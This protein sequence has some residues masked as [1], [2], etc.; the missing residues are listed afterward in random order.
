MAVKW[1]RDRTIR[2]YSARLQ[3]AFLLVASLAADLAIQ[4]EQKSAIS[5][6]AVYLATWLS[7]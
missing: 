7:D 1:S 4:R 5:A 6:R 2:L 3:T